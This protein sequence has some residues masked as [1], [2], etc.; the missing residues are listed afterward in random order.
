MLGEIARAEHELLAIGAVDLDECID[1]NTLGAALPSL[2]GHGSRYCEFGRSC[3]MRGS[4]RV[5]ASALTPGNQ[6]TSAARSARR[7]TSSTRVDSSLV[8]SRS[9]APTAGTCSRSASARRPTSACPRSQAT[10]RR[11]R[12]RQTRP[13][14]RSH[15][16]RRAMK[17]GASRCRSAR[18]ATA[19]VR[20][21]TR[22]LGARRRITRSGSGPTTVERQWLVRLE[23]G[24]QKTLSR[25]RDAAAVDRRRRR[26]ARVADLALGQDVEA[27][28]RHRGAQPVLHDRRRGA[29]ATRGEADAEAASR[30]DD[31]RRRRPTAE[32]RAR[33]PRAERSFPTT[34]TSARRPA[35]S[36][37]AARRRRRRRRATRAGQ[38]SPL[39]NVAERAGA[40]AAADRAV[41]PRASRRRRRCP[42]RRTRDRARGRRARSSS[43]DSMAAMPQGPRGGTVRRWQ[44]Q[45]AG[46]RG[47]RAVVARRRIVVPDRQGQPVGLRRRRRRRRHDRTAA[48]LARGDVDRAA[49]ARRDRG[50]RRRGLHVRVQ[51]EGRRASRRQARCRGRSRSSPMQAA[52]IVSADHRRRPPVAIRSTVR[53]PSCSP[54]IEPRMKGVYDALAPKDDPAVA[55]DAR[56]ARDAGWRR[57][58]LERAGLVADKA[59]AD[60]LRKDAKQLVIDAATARAT[61]LKAAADDPSANLA[62]ADVLR[63]Q[64]KPVKDVQRYL[65]AAKAKGAADK[66]LARSIALGRCA[67]AR[68]ATASSTTRRRRWS[69]STATA[70][71]ASSKSSRWSRTR[72]A[73]PPTPSRSSIRSS[74]RRR[75][76]MSRARLQKRLETAVAKT[77]PMPTEGSGSVQHEHET[78]PPNN[79]GGGGGGDYD[80]L[81]AKA[82]KLAEHELHEGDGALREGA[83]AEADRRR[84][85]DRHGLLLPRR[86]AV[87]ERVLEV[88]LGAR[89]V[90]AVRAGA[91]GRRRD[92][93]AAGQQGAGDRGVE[94][95]TSRRIPGSREGEEA[96]RDPRRG[97]G[98]A[99]PTPAAARRRRR[100]RRHRRRPTPDAGA[101]QRLGVV[102]GCAP[103]RAL[104][105]LIL[106]ARAVARSRR[107]SIS[108]PPT[109]ASSDPWARRR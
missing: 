28:R 60:K 36:G 64:G 66:E 19:V 50:R 7:S 55:R 49:R 65:E 27:A 48:R 12:A 2:V 15:R 22:R 101:E 29:H 75:I 17:R 81:L 56:A 24:E 96:A 58:M 80:S 38:P 89:G 61:A 99:T 39:P 5:V 3:E 8:V 70:T 76:T 68:R 10:K 88:P 109:G 23:N 93:P 71:R 94:A 86:E 106:A 16:I 105:A 51:Q 91:R 87:R 62:M 79:N 21:S 83:R 69:R 45:R 98:S 35:T 9:S 53:A 18:L 33:R 92:V 43:S 73:S 47:A 41:A 84:G 31:A 37:R 102:I 57:A 32:H 74:R 95:R 52:P 59:E 4:D 6:W 25:A 40:R 77:D 34:T 90:A 103:M 72:R 97:R 54:G 20:S 85:A 13:V 42:R 78:P 1:A 82:D 30:G 67:G 26:D 104:L 107:S 11:R 63:L 44:R 100:R 14:A 108:K 46:V